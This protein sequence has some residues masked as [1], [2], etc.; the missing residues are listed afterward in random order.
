MISALNIIA[1]F[2]FRGLGSICRKRYWDEKD[3][4]HIKERTAGTANWL[5]VKDI[6]KTMVK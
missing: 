2:P 1:S 4:K 3:R 5:M 6:S